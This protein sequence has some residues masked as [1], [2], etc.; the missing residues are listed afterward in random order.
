M[1]KKLTELAPLKELMAL[2]ALTV[3][4]ELA[5]AVP[6]DHVVRVQ[7]GQTL[8]RSVGD[9]GDLHLLQRLLVD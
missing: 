6:V 7:V 2:M 9:G 3:L 4:S 1:I 8:Q 5:A